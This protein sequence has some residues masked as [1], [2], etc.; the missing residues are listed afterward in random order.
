[1][2]NKEEIITG[3]FIDNLSFEYVETYSLLRG[4]D[5]E[6]LEIE[7]DELDNK[8]NL[9]PNEL[10]RF[11]E[12]NKYFGFTQ[13]LLDDN[14]NFHFSSNKTNT[15]KKDEKVIMELISILKI[16]PQNIADWMCAPIY[17]DAIVFYDL[18]GKIVDCLNV[19]LS[20]EHLETNKFHLLSDRK[21]YE[22]LL[23]FFKNCGHNIEDSN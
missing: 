8:Q 3:Q 20:C 17:R 7:Y 13:Y 6:K 16:K 12:L 11:S 21:V 9:N 1:M 18:N 4:K 22:G 10:E 5:F 19:C 15:F 23:V 2:T 14:G